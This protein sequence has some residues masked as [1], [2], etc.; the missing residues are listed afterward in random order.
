M[1]FFGTLPPLFRSNNLLIYSYPDSNRFSGKITGS[2]MFAK[3][4][5][6][7]RS[8]SKRLVMITRIA[9]IIML[10]L[11]FTFFIGILP[12]MADGTS[13]SNLSPNVQAN[14]KKP[15]LAQKQPQPSMLNKMTTG[16]KKFFTGVGDAL[17]FKKTSTKKTVTPTNPWIKPPKE[18]PKSS[19]F[20]SLAQKEEPKKPSSPSEWLDQKR[21]D[22]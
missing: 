13:T 14:V 9:G 17:T 5:A 11:A 10:A 15:P 18:E 4:L 21:L 19:W 2:S 6:L 3:K 22:P 1:H 16:T 7:V 8:K 12:A 20:P